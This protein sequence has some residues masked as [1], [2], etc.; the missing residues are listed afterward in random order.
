[1]FAVSSSQK[2]NKI[3]IIIPPKLKGSKTTKDESD[4]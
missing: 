3:T 2:Y 1:M 4:L